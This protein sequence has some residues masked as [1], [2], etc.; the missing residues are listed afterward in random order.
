M[1]TQ[2]MTGALRQ[3]PLWPFTLVR[4]HETKTP[5]KMHDCAISPGE[6][7]RLVAA[8]ID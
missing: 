2:T 3:R 6:L 7:R 8:M 1:T 4:S 5:A